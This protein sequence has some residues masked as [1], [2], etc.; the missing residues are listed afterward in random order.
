METQSEDED[1]H[2]EDRQ[3]TLGIAE[4][5]GLE[6]LVLC[7]AGALVLIAGMNIK[8]LPELR[9]SIIITWSFYGVTLD[10]T[11]HFFHGTCR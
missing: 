7:A 11:L 8:Q 9:S 1:R 4:T 3:Q 2:A 10:V 5:T 6:K